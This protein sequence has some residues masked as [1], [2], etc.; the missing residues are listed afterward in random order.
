MT[1]L[2]SSLGA[3]LDDR[4]PTLAGALSFATI[5]A[6]A[7]LFVIIMALTGHF[8]SSDQ[9]QQ[10]LINQASRAVGHDGATALQA[11]VVSARANA[12]VTSIFGVIGWLTLL[13]AAS[14]IFLTLQDALNIIWH[15]EVRKNVP[16]RD[17]LRE[18]AGALAMVFAMAFLLIVTFATDAAVAVA[19]TYLRSVPV[20]AQFGWLLQIASTVLSLAVATLLFA[21]AFKVL[22]QVR[23][24]WRDV[25]EGAA[26][27][28]VLFIAGQWIIAL[29]LQV[30]G[31]TKGYG[32]AGS[33]LALLM[34]I[35]VS[36]MFLFLGAE[37]VKFR[38]LEA[39]ARPKA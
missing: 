1:A 35:Y 6:L 5:F 36:A 15:V 24:A 25:W 11:M 34:W 27:S 7:P 8:I 29:F 33:I 20:V 26:L 10:H 13:G 21:I 14:G 2:R 39:A 9:V 3:W 16:I 38:T 4:S 30:A 22:P 28:A 31:L 19:V 23:I 32:A 37:L 18:R 12:R 17:V